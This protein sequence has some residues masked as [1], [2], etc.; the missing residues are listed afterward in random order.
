MHNISFP[1]LVILWNCD[2]KKCNCDIKRY[3]YNIKGCNTK[4]I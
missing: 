2:I 3:N 1:K 4:E